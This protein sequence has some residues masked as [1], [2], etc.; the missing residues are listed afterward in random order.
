MNYRQLGEGQVM[1]GEGQRHS[2]LQLTFMLPQRMLGSIAL[3]VTWGSTPGSFS[4]LSPLPLRL[5]A[6]LPQA[7]P[8]GSA[9]IALL[10]FITF[11]PCLLCLGHLISQASL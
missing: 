1:D 8:D 3:D 6:V 2:Y 4:L 11:C 5:L 9:F 10:A 7:I